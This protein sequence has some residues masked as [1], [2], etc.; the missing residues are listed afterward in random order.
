MGGGEDW[1]VGSG[2][3]EKWRLAEGSW[4]REIETPEFE[5]L[6]ETAAR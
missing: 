3:E 1:E 5:R 2:S 4:S 6:H